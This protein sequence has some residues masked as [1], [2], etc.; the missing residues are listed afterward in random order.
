MR[1]LFNATSDGESLIRL[2][3]YTSEGRPTLWRNA[4]KQICEVISR[5]PLNVERCWSSEVSSARARRGTI[6]VCNLECI[7]R[8]NPPLPDI[9][10]AVGDILVVSKCDCVE[11]H[12]E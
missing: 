1:G 6:F 11:G 10:G 3:T 8:I 12:L 5:V 7:C 2:R 9:P 4:M